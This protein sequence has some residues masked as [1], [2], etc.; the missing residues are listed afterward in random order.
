MSHTFSGSETVTVT[1]PVEVADLQFF[2]YSV[3]GFVD[4]ELYGCGGRGGGAVSSSGGAGGGAGAHVKSVK[5]WV[6]PGEKHYYRIRAGSE[7]HSGSIGGSTEINLNPAFS[8]SAYP[9]SCSS[10]GDGAGR[11]A[12]AA[13]S[14]GYDNAAL[15]LFDIA[16]GAGG[17]TAL[18]TVPGSG[19]GGVGILVTGTD[20][21]AS[22][23]V[24]KGSGGVTGGGDGGDVG[25]PNGVTPSQVGAGGGGAFFPGGTRGNGGEGQII[26]TFTSAATLTTTLT[27]AGSSTYVCP[28]TGSLTIGT[29]GA[30]AQPAKYGTSSAGGF[31]GGAYSQKTITVA[32]GQILY[33]VVGDTS[34]NSDGSSLV[35]TT[36]MDPADPLTW[37]HAIVAASGGVIN[38]NPRT[39]GVGG[40]DTT[41]AYGGSADGVTT[42]PGGNGGNGVNGGA[43]G[44]GG[45][46]AGSGGAGGNGSGTTGG[47]AGANGALLLGAGAAGGTGGTATGNGAAGVAP[48]SGPGGG[49]NGNGHV[50]GAGAAGQAVFY[51]V[52]QITVPVPTNGAGLMMGSN[53]S[54]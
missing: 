13:G 47:L 39:G 15:V 26:A 49:G 50:G 10:G 3:P 22:S 29:W 8:D 24:T 27:T 2:L 19:G 43:G 17:A 6:I 45:G 25:S 21:T 37:T 46:S 31:G 51:F 44:G 38:G 54:L 36:W 42:Y 7:V 20:G 1:G 4:Y 32:D 11:T 23:G 48:G 35:G 5:V 18:L 28:G 14:G 16:G 40:F 12:G 30:T 53:L 9:I 34:G 41:V 52:G 33:V